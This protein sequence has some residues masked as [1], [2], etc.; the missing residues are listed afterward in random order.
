MRLIAAGMLMVLLGPA[1]VAAARAPL[2]CLAASDPA[3]A[4]RP[5]EDLE[6]LEFYSDDGDPLRSYSV[7]LSRVQSDLD[8][9]GRRHNGYSIRGAPAVGAAIVFSGST[10]LS[11]TLVALRKTY[12]SLEKNEDETAFMA[13]AVPGVVCYDVTPRE[14]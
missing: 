9:E 1:S 3:D 12:D 11:F 4:S 2:V 8:A 6:A 5:I 7:P 13:D 14:P 10:P